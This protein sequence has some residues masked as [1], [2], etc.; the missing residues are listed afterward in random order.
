MIFGEIKVKFIAIVILGQQRV[1]PFVDIYSIDRDWCINV[2]LTTIK[3]IN[4]GET[5]YHNIAQNNGI[6]RIKR[7][8]MEKYATLVTSQNTL[9]EST[10]HAVSWRRWRWWSVL[11]P[12]YPNFAPFS[13]TYLIILSF[14]YAREWINSRMNKAE[15]KTVSVGVSIVMHDDHKHRFLVVANPI[16]G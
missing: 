5:C 10:T 9:H 13:I 11:L 8:Q 4:N 16:Q 12:I 3:Q 14:V 6:T 15:L 7:I 2:I 1:M